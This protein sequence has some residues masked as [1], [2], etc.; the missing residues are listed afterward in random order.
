[1]SSHRAA[2]AA[3]VMELLPHV[4]H[5]LRHPTGAAVMGALWDKAQGDMRDAMASTFY[6]KEFAVLKQVCPCVEL[7]ARMR[8]G[9]PML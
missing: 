9:A 4:P 3:L 1:M 5:L 8:A 7:A 2:C 6:G